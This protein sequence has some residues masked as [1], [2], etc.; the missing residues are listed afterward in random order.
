MWKN[1]VERDGQ[2]K[3][4]WGTRIA[5]WITKATNTHT[6]CILLIFHCNNGYMNATQCYVTRTPPVLFKKEV[7]FRYICEQLAPAA[8]AHLNKAERLSWCFGLDR[9]PSVHK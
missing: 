5:C 4:I 1:S 8:P 9:H 7:S 6:D 2:L 3:T